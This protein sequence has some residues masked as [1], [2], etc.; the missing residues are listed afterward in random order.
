MSVRNWGDTH[1]ALA[2]MGTRPIWEGPLTAL[3]RLFNVRDDV[4]NMFNSYR[5]TDKVREN[6]SGA[7][8]FSAELAMRS[9]CRMEHTAAHIPHM[10]HHGDQLRCFHKASPCLYPTFY[11]K[12]EDPT[13]TFGE[14][15]L[16]EGVARVARQPR[17]RYPADLG[18]LL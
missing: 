18:M 5:K 7:L 9:A 1:A 6:S 2:Q 13:G 8:F 11:P 10:Y 14:I 3:Q 16:C 4:V 12:G 15:L 17:V